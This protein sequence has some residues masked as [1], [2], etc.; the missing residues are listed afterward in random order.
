MIIRS[1]INHGN[2]LKIEYMLGNTCN[3]KCSYCF[4]GSNE[5]DKSWPNYNIAIENLKHLIS[6]Y[7]KPVLMYFVGGE[8]TLWKDFPKFCR[9]LKKEFNIT[10]TIS[11]NGSRKLPWWKKNID[12]FDVVHVSVHHEFSNIPQIKQLMD[13][14]YDSYIETNV[15][16]LIDPAKFNKCINIVEEL[17]LKTKPWTIIAKIVLFNGTSRYSSE[18]EYYFDNMYKR[19]PPM[20]WYNIV[21][22]KE[23]SLITINTDTDSFQTNNNS[24][25]ALH[26]VNKFKGWKCNLGVDILKIESNG[27]IHGNCGQFLYGEKFKYN[28]Y[29]KNFIKNFNPEIKPVICTKETCPCSG[30]AATTK[31]RLNA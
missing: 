4:P 30:E 17:K 21:K 31:S 22:K 25:F 24:W 12:C 19:M 16:V 7:N 20:D 27:T 15:D 14:L 1:I 11:T 29:D 26:G 28:L 6:K 5:G 9:E 18:Q 8:P 2:A 13:F 10:I 3:Y 23:T